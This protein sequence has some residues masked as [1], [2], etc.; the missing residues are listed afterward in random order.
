MSEY[1][2]ELYHHGIKGQRWG[3]RRFQNEDG[4]LT[5]AGRRRYTSKITEQYRKE[6]GENSKEYK[7]SKELDNKINEYRDNTSRGKAIAKNLLL[8]SSGRLTYDM[9]RSMGKSRG[10]AAVRSMFDINVASLVSGGITAI[11]SD[12]QKKLA[13]NGMNKTATAVGGAST[14]AGRMADDVITSRGGELSLQQRA[15]RKKY[16]KR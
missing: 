7:R 15:L 2:L 10:E 16:V 4:S 14:V 8:G 12:A 1:R 6:Y 5:S 3:V 9:A 13:L 11:G